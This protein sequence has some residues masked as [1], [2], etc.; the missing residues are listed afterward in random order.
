MKDFVSFLIEDGAAANVAAGMQSP[1]NIIGL[2]RA[3]RMKDGK[4][5]T[6]KK[7]NEGIKFATRDFLRSLGEAALAGFEI[8]NFEKSLGMNMATNMNLADYTKMVKDLSDHGIAIHSVDTDPAELAP[9]QRNFD[10]NKVNRLIDGKLYVHPIIT[11]QDGYVIDGHHRWL[12]AVKDGAP[13]IAA[14]QIQMP[15]AEALDWLKD[16]QYPRNKDKLTEGSKYIPGAGHIGG[17]DDEY[18]EEM[19]QNSAGEMVPKHDPKPYH[20]KQ[21]STYS[22]PKIQHFHQVEFKNKDSAKSEGMKWDAKEKGWFHEDLN[23]SQASKHPY[24][25]SV[26]YDKIDFHGNKVNRTEW[27][28]PQVDGGVRDGFVYQTTDADAPTEDTVKDEPTEDES[29]LQFVHDVKY[30]QK[31]NAKQEGMLW[32]PVEKHWYHVDPEKSKASKFPFKKT[33]SNIK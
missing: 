15:A 4:V 5:P 30:M 18:P 19:E 1:D 31:D 8:P 24:V 9:T 29:N 14:R 10:W 6:G 28:R 3:K 20:K 25:K 16:K 26:R 23:K 32:D 17:G 2:P 13:I 7:V 11:S 33:V 12:A 22:G 21:Y 27:V